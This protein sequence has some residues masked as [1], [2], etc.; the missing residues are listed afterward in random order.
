MTG[1]VPIISNLKW[2]NHSSAIRFM[3]NVGEPSGY[4]AS[5]IYF[6]LKTTYLI[7]LNEKCKAVGVVYYYYP[8][9]SLHSLQVL[10][11]TIIRIMKE[12]HA[13]CS[14]AVSG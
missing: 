13:N 11:P 7:L 10:C 12:K 6:S 1:C 9:S 8:R 5:I 2:A 4:V 3:P 14:S